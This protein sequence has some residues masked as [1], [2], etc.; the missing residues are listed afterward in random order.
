MWSRVGHPLIDVMAV[1][2]QS[3][4]TSLGAD[5]LLDNILKEVEVCIMIETEQWT[6]Q[7][8][9]LLDVTAEICIWHHFHCSPFIAIAL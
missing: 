7:T 3:D 4:T 2:F 8:K 1:S 6:D 5:D 9:R